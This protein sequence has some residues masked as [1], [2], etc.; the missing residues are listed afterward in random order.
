MENVTNVQILELNKRIQAS[1]TRTETASAAK[2]VEAQKKAILE[3]RCR[4][5]SEKRDTVQKEIDAQQASL[6]ILLVRQEVR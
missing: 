1:R 4:E 6:E 3:N 2:A 5:E